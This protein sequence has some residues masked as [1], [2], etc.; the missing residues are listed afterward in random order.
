[1]NLLIALKYLKALLEFALNHIREVMIVFLTVVL[2]ATITS[3][4]NKIREIK[5]LKAEVEHVQTECALTLTTEKAAYEVAKGKLEREQHDKT[6][7]AINDAQTRAKAD[8]IAAATA[9]A[10]NL[11]LSDTIDKQAAVAAV[12]AQYRIEYAATTGQLLKDCSGYLTKLAR[13]ADGHV[14]DIRLLQDARGKR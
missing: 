6:I 14:N 7:Q 3:C 11:S 5:Y 12:D 4:S 9:S 13:V 8:A 2:I 10:L 1:M